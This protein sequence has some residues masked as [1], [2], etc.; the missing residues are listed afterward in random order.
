MK[1]NGQTLGEPEPRV[2]VFTRKG[3]DFVFK[4]KPVYD[5]TEFDKICPEPVQRTS[6]VHGPIVDD[7]YKKRVSDYY[8]RKTE[9]AI[10]QAL[11]ATDGL[12]WDTIV[13]DD[14]ETWKNYEKELSDAGL[15]SGEMVYLIEQIN[16]VNSVDEKVMEAARDRFIASQEADQQHPLSLNTEP[17][18]I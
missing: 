14:P 18:T 8:A 2:I 4:V 17:M 5:F 15:T 3:Q 6:L 13:P 16:A 7:K 11:S 1:I 12:E 10:L 9:W